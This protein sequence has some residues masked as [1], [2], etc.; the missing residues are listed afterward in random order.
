LIHK[1][2]HS[3]DEVDD[4]GDDEWSGVGLHLREKVGTLPDVVDVEIPLEW[5]LRQCIAKLYEL[6]R[7]DFHLFLVIAL[8][9]DK[10]RGPRASFGRF[11]DCSLLG[12]VFR[13]G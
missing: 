4:N 13:L 3:D 11:F 5:R 8:E 1:Q 7:A 2:R 10:R 6:P 9:I 12:D